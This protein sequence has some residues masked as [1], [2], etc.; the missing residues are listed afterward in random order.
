MTDNDFNFTC[1]GYLALALAGSHDLTEEQKKE[2]YHNI[3]YYGFD[4]KT[5]AEA[6]KIGKEVGLAYDESIAKKYLW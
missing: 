2:V 3:Q 1:L 5:I 4:V 6:Q